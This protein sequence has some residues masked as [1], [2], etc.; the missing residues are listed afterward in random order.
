MIYSDHIVGFERMAPDELGAN[1]ANFRVHPDGQRTAWRAIAERV[2]WLGAL[3]WNR[4]TGHLIDGH[5][6]ETV[7][8]K[9]ARG[10]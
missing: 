1:P 9:A 4:R 8:D 7:L 3:I 5:L 10:G 2:G 6:R